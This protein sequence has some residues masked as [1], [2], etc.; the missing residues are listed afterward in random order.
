MKYWYFW[1]KVNETIGNMHFGD[2]LLGA[3]EGG[4]IGHPNYFLGNIAHCEKVDI[5]S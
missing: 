5:I 2:P 4:R 1:Q 3:G